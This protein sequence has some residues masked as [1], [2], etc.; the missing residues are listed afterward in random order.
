MY[1]KQL[2]LNY[3]KENKELFQKKYDIDTIALYGSYAKNQQ[4]KSSD[5]DILV[6]SHKKIKDIDKLKQNLQLHFKST[7]DI[8]DE[9]NIILPTM[10]KMITKECLYV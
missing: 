4:T 8:L 3:L 10:K 7:I 5:I 1:T 9:K 2:I 6:S